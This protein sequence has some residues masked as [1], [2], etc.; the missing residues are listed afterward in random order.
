MDFLSLPLAAFEDILYYAFV[1]HSVFWARGWSLLIQLWINLFN[2]NISS[3]AAFAFDVM[4]KIHAFTDNLFVSYDENTNVFINNVDENF[5][6]NQWAT[7]ESGF[8]VQNN[9]ELTCL[10]NNDH[11]ISSSKFHP[12]FPVKPETPI[13][14]FLN[15]YFQPTHLVIFEEPTLNDH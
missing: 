4:N 6:K 3:S 12:L 9:W 15:D 5:I 10:F 7:P 1:D 8:F 14:S 2:L 11:P 13:C